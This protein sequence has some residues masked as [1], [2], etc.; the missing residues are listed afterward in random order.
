MFS[1]VYTNFIAYSLF[2]QVS[3]CLNSLTKHFN[4]FVEVSS[5]FIQSWLQFHLFFFFK[6][7]C[8]LLENDL[9]KRTKIQQ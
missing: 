5:A 4:D 8:I 2:Y 7:F 1:F 6:T 9:L 3:V